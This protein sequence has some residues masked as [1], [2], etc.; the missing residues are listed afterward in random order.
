MST[1]Y[2]RICDN[3]GNMQEQRTGK[4][5][6]PY[7]PDYWWHWLHITGPDLLLPQAVTLDFCSIKCL[8]AWAQEQEELWWTEHDK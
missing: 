7:D 2:Q 1:I 4:E 5:Q 6:T 3:C 8:S